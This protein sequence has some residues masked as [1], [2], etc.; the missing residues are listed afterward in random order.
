[1]RPEAVR[2]LVARA[3]TGSGADG[4]GRLL[5]PD[6]RRRLRA[7]LALAR[8]GGHSLA[9]VVHAGGDATGHEV[10][11]PWSPPPPATQRHRRR[12]WLALALHVE[13]GRV[14]GVWASRPQAR[15]LPSRRSAG[16]PAGPALV[17]AHHVV[18]ACGA[19]GSCT[20]SPP[21]FPLHG[22]GVAMALAAG[23][24]VADVEFMQFHPTALHH[25]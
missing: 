10:D 2:V 17:R 24:A 12:G 19:P 5:R 25:R 15:P 1:V 8:E 18:L 16:G 23:A 6:G 21:T 4:A 14:A 9:R 3:P 7:P 11:G 22:D 13:D 20:R